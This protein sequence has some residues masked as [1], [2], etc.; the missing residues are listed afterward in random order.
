M[1]GINISYFIEEIHSVVPHKLTYF[2]YKLLLSG[3][4]NF[5]FIEMRSHVPVIFIRN[6]VSLSFQP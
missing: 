5:C 4:I 2:V 3:V 6:N 1:V